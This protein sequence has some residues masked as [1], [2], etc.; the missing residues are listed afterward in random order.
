MICCL[1]WIV[2]NCRGIHGYTL[3]RWLPWSQ[4]AVSKSIVPNKL[5]KFWVSNPKELLETLKKMKRDWENWSL[6]QSCFLFGSYYFNSA[7]F[8][9]KH[10]TTIDILYIYIYFTCPLIERKPGRGKPISIMGILHGQFRVSQIVFSWS[11][12][13]E[14]MATDGSPLISIDG[15]PVWWFPWIERDLSY[16]IIMLPSGKLT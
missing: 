6:F 1:A 15:N 4:S 2:I 11:V 5:S 16:V 13:L 7:Y 8:R 9:G 10:R 3:I 14:R 12:T